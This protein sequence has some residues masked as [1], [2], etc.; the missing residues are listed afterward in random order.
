MGKLRA[1][2]TGIFTGRDGYNGVS[3]FIGCSKLLLIF[4]LAG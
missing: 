1:F 2:D 3:V 4:V